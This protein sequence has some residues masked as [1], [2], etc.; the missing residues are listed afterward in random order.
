MGSVRPS[1][2]WKTCAA[3]AAGG[4]VADLNMQI[5]MAN[6]KKIAYIEDLQHVAEFQVHEAH[7]LYVS[8]MQV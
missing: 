5:A 2:K 8:F 1:I 7:Q 6:T 3:T 4:S